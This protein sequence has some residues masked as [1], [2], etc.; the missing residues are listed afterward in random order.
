MTINGSK[1]LREELKTLKSKD[2]PEII[3]AIATARGFGDLKENAEYHAA[4][5]K[6]SF[7][8]G[9][10]KDIE[11]KLSNA[12]IIDITELNVSN[13]VV[14]GSTVKILNIESEKQVKY[15]LVGEDESDI[16]KGLLSYKAPVSRAIIGKSIDEIIEIAKSVANR[17]RFFV[18]LDTLEYLERG[19]RIGKAQALMGSILK[20]KPILSLKDGLVEPLDKARTRT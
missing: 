4:K 3:Q 12:E 20:I 15:K 17:C 7:I 19:G 6:Q 14:F 5:E 10:I 11:S 1:L 9:R 2:R 18:M 13:K 16:D 8:E